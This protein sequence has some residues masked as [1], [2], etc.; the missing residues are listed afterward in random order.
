[1][2]IVGQGSA[3]LRPRLVLEVECSAQVRCSGLLDERD[4]LKAPVGR[5]VPGVPGDAAHCVFGTEQGQQALAGWAQGV[6]IGPPV[7]AAR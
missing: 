7:R 2:R 5:L 4:P 1:M 6:G 3:H